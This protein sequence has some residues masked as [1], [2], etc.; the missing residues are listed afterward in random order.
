MWKLWLSSYVC[1]LF[2][3]HSYSSESD[4]ESSAHRSGLWESVSNQSVTLNLSALY[5]TKMEQ[6]ESIRA[7]WSVSWNWPTCE[8]ERE[9]S[10]IMENVSQ[11]RLGTSLPG[12]FSTIPAPNHCWLQQSL[13][14]SITYSLH[15]SFTRRHRCVRVLTQINTYDSSIMIHK[16]SVRTV[17]SLY[18]SHLQKAPN[19]HVHKSQPRSRVYMHTYTAHTDTHRWQFSDLEN[20]RRSIWNSGKVL[21]HGLSSGHNKPA[22][23]QP[24]GDGNWFFKRINRIW[25]LSFCTQIQP[26]LSLPPSI[27][28][29]IWAK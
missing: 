29:W 16:H 24:M 26:L 8:R 22:V 15:Y 2:Q 5:W 19:V 17:N 20:N 14:I 11:P 23:C 27:N 25:Q 12:L 9:K 18:I 3:L 4:T 13:V 28:K 7:Q 21:Y 1:V 6:G 10:F